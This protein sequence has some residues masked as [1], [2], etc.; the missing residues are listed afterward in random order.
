MRRVLAL[1]AVRGKDS[2]LGIRREPRWGRELGRR[3][4]VAGPFLWRLWW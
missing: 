4:S 2:V 1:G 3:E